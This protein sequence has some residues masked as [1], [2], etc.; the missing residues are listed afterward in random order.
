V[1]RGKAIKSHSSHDEAKPGKLMSGYEAVLHW[2]LK[3]RIKTLLICALLFVVTLTA[4][5]PQLAVSFLPNGKASRTMYFALKLPY[6]TAFDATD[7]KTKELEQLLM[8]TKDSNG[9]PVFTYV[10]ALVGYSGNDDEQTSYASQIYVEVNE[11]VDPDK[12]K[13]QVKQFILSELPQ[14]SEVQ[15]RSLG[16]GGGFSSTD[17]SYNLK[18]DDQDKLEQAAGIIKAK[19]AEFPELSEVEDSLSDGKTEVE[20]AV[21]QKKARTYGLTASSVKDTAA[22]W[23]QKQSL[24]DLKFDGITYTT[25]VSMSKADKNSLE[26]LGNIPLTSK[27]GSTVYLK[28]VAKISLL[29]APASLRRENQ[30]QLASVTAKINS[31]NKNAVSAKLSMALKAV[32]L[33]DGVSRETK[34]VSADINESFSQLFLAMGVAVFMVYLVMVLAFGNAAAPFAILFSLP[35]AAIGGLIGLVITKEALNIT[36]MIG[37]MMLIGIVVTNAIVLIDRAQ[38]MR[39][40]GYTVRQALLDAGKVRLRPII[41]T[42]GATIMALVPLALG[43]S[44]EGGLIGKGLG[45]VVI[46]GLTTS[47]ILTLIVVPIVYELIEEFKNRVARLFNRPVNS[48]AA[49]NTLEL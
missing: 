46:G 24:G 27:S 9:K 25:T 12:V 44:G 2:S 17:F 8:D 37:F 35:L 41:M 6:E 21:D 47:T 14:G 23:L 45:V 38:Q 30:E 13:E 18:G 36:S 28:E 10:E 1:L 5:I 26:K 20:I 29:Q 40:E 11:Q 16:G 4:T 43:L 33:P 49:V 7:E 48:S 32:E 42:A 39:E 19:L 15:P 31:E 22:I 34:G 3:N